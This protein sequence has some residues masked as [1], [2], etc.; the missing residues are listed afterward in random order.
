MPSILLTRPRAAAERM[1]EE[2]RRLGYDSAVEPLLTVVPSLAPPPDI[3]GVSAVMITSANALA[4]PLPAAL[5]SLLQRPCFCVGARTAAAA[6]AFGFQDA[7]SADG[8]GADLAQLIADSAGGKSVLHIAGQET[9][10]KAQD[11]LRRKGFT[12][13]TWP[14]YA[15]VPAVE[16]SPQTVAL[17]RDG[18]IDAVPVF[19]PRTAELLKTLLQR[20]ALPACCGRLIAI[21]MSEAVTE[22]LRPLPW[23]ILAAA[24]RPT[25]ES[26]IARLQELCHRL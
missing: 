8:D 12:V 7:R 5:Q 11:I 10:G 17:I 19:S 21:G 15:V 6:R 20:H 22:A 23:R 24:E 4:W 1:A 14:V 26:V 9:Y 18:K 3:K 13:G 16:F 2:L 25:E